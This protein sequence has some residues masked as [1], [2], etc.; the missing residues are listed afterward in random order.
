MI[1]F[2]F[3]ISIKDNVTQENDYDNSDTKINQ[4]IVTH[5]IE[6]EEDF[7]D[8]IL[9]FLTL[10]LGRVASLLG[11]KTRFVTHR[12]KGFLYMLLS[13]RNGGGDWT[14]RGKTMVVFSE[15]CV[16]LFFLVLKT[17]TLFVSECRAWGYWKLLFRRLLLWA[18]A[19]SNLCW[20]CSSPSLSFL[21]HNWNLPFFLV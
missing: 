11:S 3:F 19:W 1:V 20:R 4:Q 15:L 10:P 6:A 16:I 17:K 9:S 7:V 8:F 12:W 2:F 21:I 13:Q 5:H 18:I 14:E